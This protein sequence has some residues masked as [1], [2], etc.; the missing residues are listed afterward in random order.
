MKRI[1]LLAASIILTALAAMSALAQ[2]PAQAGTGK[3]GWL[4]TTEFAN[5]NGG[6]AKYVNALKAID[7]EMQPRATELQTISNKIKTIAGDLQ[8]MQSN[9]AIPVD[10]AAFAAKQ[11]EGQRLQREGEFKQKEYE[12][13]VEKRK[14]DLLG[15]ITADILKAVQ[16]FAK[17]KGYSVILD[18]APLDQAHAILMLDANAEVTKDFITYYNARP[19]SATASTT[20]PK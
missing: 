8:K 2:T 11:D 7:T 10:Q 12:A 20:A 13:A 14:T 18:I 4:D 19:A 15:P 16:D 1:S 3:I 9:P 17:A 5:P 6:I